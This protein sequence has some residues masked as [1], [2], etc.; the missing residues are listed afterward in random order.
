MIFQNNKKAWVI[1]AVTLVLSVPAF[2]Y[3][4]GRYP[5]LCVSCYTGSPSPAGKHGVCEDLVHELQAER[6][7][8]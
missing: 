6:Y 2:F 5:D 1:F 3:A 7:A 4:E 8:E